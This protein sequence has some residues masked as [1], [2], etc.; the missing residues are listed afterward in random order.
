MCGTA[1]VA[2]TFSEC[3]PVSSER[4]PARGVAADAEAVIVY[5][6]AVVPGRHCG[7]QREI[8]HKNTIDDILPFDF[9]HASDVLVANNENLSRAA[10]VFVGQYRYRLPGSGW[11]C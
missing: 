9:F 4:S 1:H 6:K 5:S 7:D 3:W 10:G 2:V 8:I 11:F